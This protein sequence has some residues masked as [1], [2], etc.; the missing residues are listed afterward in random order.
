MKINRV[1]SGEV[2]RISLVEAPANGE[3]ICGEMFC[4][5]EGDY[6]TTIVLNAN[7]VIYRAPKQDQE[8]Y[9]FFM[10][11][12]VVKTMA[13]QFLERNMN[14][15]LSR[16][17]SPFTDEG[18]KLS[19]SWVENGVWRV[20]IKVLDQ[21][22]MDRVHNNTITGASIESINIMEMVLEITDDIEKFTADARALDEET[23][24]ILFGDYND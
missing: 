13:H 7:Q 1:I 18:L 23:K 20:K 24:Y 17:H 2:N 3:T 4:S 12:E 8:E 19:E 9:F 16:D 5:I 15:N 6:I 11:E 10:T 21:A 14:N 22:I